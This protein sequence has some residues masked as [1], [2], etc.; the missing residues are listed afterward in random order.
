MLETNESTRLSKTKKDE[1]EMERKGRER[2]GS[3][4]TFKAFGIS[5]LV[6]DQA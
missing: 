6:P 5:K 3:V 4:S 1:H 2:E